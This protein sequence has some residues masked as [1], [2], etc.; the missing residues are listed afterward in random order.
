M[1]SAMIVRRCP[2]IQIIPIM[3]MLSID[4]LKHYCIQLD[5]AAGKM[6]F[7]EPEH[8]NAVQLGKA[9]PII[10]TEGRPLFIT[11]AWSK[12]WAPIR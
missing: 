5:F 4:C 12:A 10:W 9:F 1:S 6:R 3:G 11:M 7:L 8:V 2:L